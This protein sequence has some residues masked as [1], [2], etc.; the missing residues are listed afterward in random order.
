MYMSMKKL[1]L[2][3]LDMSSNLQVTYLCYFVIKDYYQNY[4]TTSKLCFSTN[5]EYISIY[6]HAYRIR[7]NI[8]LSTIPAYQK[9]VL[10]EL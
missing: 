4:H 3:A 7:I 6:Y 8:R 9:M 5:F 10:L 1:L 2:G